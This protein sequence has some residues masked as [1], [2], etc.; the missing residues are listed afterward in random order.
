[1][2][3][4][5]KN[6]NSFNKK[7][8]YNSKQKIWGKNKNKNFYNKENFWALNL[9]R[10]YLKDEYYVSIGKNFGT[11]FFSSRKKVYRVSLLF[12]A[13]NFFCTLSSFTTGEVLYSVSCGNYKIKVSK[14]NL[15]YTFKLVLEKFFRIILRKVK[16]SNLI[17]NIVAPLHIRRKLVQTLS[18]YLNQR[19]FLIRLSNLKC[20]NGC[21]PCKRRRKKR[22]GLRFER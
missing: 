13:N 9:Y 4:E 21:R 12:K 1:M 14:R 11:P 2:Q 6:L 16:L 22:K 5:K 10:K 15:K 17:I 19:S 8:N 3:K 18:L 20:F 7:N